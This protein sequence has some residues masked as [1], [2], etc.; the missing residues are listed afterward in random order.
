LV[1]PNNEEFQSSSGSLFSNEGSWMT[2]RKE[3]IRNVTYWSK[4]ILE[5]GELIFSG[6]KFKNKFFNAITGKI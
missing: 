4:G 6:I 2:E 5:K 1:L 3:K